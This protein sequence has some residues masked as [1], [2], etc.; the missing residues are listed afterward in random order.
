MMPQARLRALVCNAGGAAIVRAV[1]KIEARGRFER[2]PSAAG[3]ALFVS[4]GGGGAWIDI[5]GWRGGE[6]PDVLQDPS[7]HAEV[8]DPMRWRLRHAG[9]DSGFVAAGVTLI[10]PRPWLL[11]PLGAPFVLRPG[12]RRAARVLLAL[13]RLPGG[14]RLLRAWHARRG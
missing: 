9:G 13:L 5:A 2:Q 10:E 4:T 6:L 3:R 8:S 1:T 14:A 7:F 12:E 11:D